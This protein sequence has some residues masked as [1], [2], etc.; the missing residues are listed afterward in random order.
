MDEQ[1]ER[2]KNM[3][4]AA[5]VIK[6]WIPRKNSELDKVVALKAKTRA[7]I[8]IL[9]LDTKHCCMYCVEWWPP[10]DVSTWNL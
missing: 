9:D 7:R 3:D 6:H 4:V 1:R 2:Y 10:K 8:G 5:L